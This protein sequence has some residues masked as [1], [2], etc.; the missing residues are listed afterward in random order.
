MG[1]ELGFELGFEFVNNNNKNYAEHRTDQAGKW[2]LSLTA[3][4]LRLAFAPPSC[5]RRRHTSSSVVISRHLS[6]SLVHSPFLTLTTH[7]RIF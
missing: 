1:F 6:S 2:R 4:Q 7:G 5:F 3:G